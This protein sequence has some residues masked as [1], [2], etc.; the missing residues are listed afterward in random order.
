MPKQNR[1]Q[2]STVIKL[3]FKGQANTWAIAL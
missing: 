1:I 3:K 2:S